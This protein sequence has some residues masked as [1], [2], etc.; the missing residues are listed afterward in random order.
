MYYRDLGL[1][2]ASVDFASFQALPADPIH[3]AIVSRVDSAQ[4]VADLCQQFNWVVGHAADGKKPPTLGYPVSEQRLTT[5]P[6]IRGHRRG[7]LTGIALSD[8]QD[9]CNLPNVQ[10]DW[11]QADGYRQS[12]NVIDVKA[13][14]SVLT[15]SNYLQYLTG[16]GDF[17]VA[18]R[19]P[20]IPR[21]LPALQ[22]PAIRDVRAT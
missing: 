16:F 2:A 21:E 11:T 8:I 12:S 6:S 14:P 13:D 10:W 20:G 17:S 7:S 18:R 22:L 1:G 4:R 5:C 15:S 3:S 19:L 9:L